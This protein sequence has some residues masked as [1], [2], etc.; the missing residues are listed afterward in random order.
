MSSESQQQPAVDRWVRVEAPSL[1][2]A[3]PPVI[4]S[5]V[6]S[7]IEP[8]AGMALLTCFLVMALVLRFFT[9]VEKFR[10]EYVLPDDALDD[11]VERFPAPV[12][13]TEEGRGSAND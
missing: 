7:A 4:T 11:V 10:R 12:I 5:F 3:V 1:Y 6:L 9:R 2:F 13:V 8:M